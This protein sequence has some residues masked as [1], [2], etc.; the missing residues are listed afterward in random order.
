[1]NYTDGI[2]WW[3]LLFFLQRL[4]AWALSCLAGLHC[5]LWPP[6]RSSSQRAR[7]L[8]KKKTWIKL[9][10]AP[11]LLAAAGAGLL[12]L[13]TAQ[14]PFFLWLSRKNIELKGVS[15]L[16][17]CY[18]AQLAQLD[19]R[20]Q[21]SKANVGLKPRKTEKKKLISWLSMFLMKAVGWFMGAFVGGKMLLSVWVLLC[22]GP[23]VI[24]SDSFRIILFYNII[25]NIIPY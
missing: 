13:S 20:L 2:K 15:Q 23:Y 3:S 24:D 12:T 18:L 19:V 8:R 16:Y 21:L 14:A 22:C 10:L 25:L 6:L 11:T 4:R 1:M 17:W 5:S 7:F 9:C